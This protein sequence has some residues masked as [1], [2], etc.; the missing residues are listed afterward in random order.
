MDLSLNDFLKL[1]NELSRS[2]ISTVFFHSMTIKDNWI[3]QDFSRLEFFKQIR[4]FFQ[5]AKR[6]SFTVNTN[7]HPPKVLQQRFQQPKTSLLNPKE[8]FD[9]PAQKHRPRLFVVCKTAVLKLL[10]YQFCYFQLFLQVILKCQI[11]ILFVV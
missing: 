7:W 3:M 6:S 9:T 5:P 4:L 8:G 10:I 1:I 2:H 11:S